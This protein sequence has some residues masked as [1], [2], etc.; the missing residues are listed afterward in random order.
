MKKI[1]IAGEIYNPNIGDQAIYV[2]LNS[3]IKN[4]FHISTKGIDISGRTKPDNLESNTGSNYKFPRLI[5]QAA[6]PS[7]NRLN[8]LIK[9]MRGEFTSWESNFQDADALI[10]GGAG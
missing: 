8:L 7:L 3:L 1:L 9:K 2:C 5:H 10:I 6:G 4:H